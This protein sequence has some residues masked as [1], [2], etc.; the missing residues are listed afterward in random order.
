MRHDDQ[1]GDHL[2]W[3]KDDQLSIV[4]NS[5]FNRAELQ[6]L[7]IWP[8]RFLIRNERHD[9]RSQH[10]LEA[11]TSQQHLVVL[12]VVQAIDDLGDEDSYATRD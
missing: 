8:H 4:H 11:E 5:L 7:C 9:V 2:R 3:T 10:A 6:R 12:A 1:A